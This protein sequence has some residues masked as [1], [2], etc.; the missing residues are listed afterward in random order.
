MSENT[1]TIE[2]ASNLNNFVLNNLA[3]EKINK[4]QANDPRKML[5]YTITESLRRDC[6]IALINQGRSEFPNKSIADN[7]D[8]GTKPS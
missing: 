4:V 8:N 6:I 7:W 1:K 2:D 5:K 3:I